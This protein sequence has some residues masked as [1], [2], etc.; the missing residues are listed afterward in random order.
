MAFQV[1][2]VV[3]TVDGSRTAPYGY[4][5]FANLQRYTIPHPFFSHRKD[6]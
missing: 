3:V 1:G 4:G 2:G 6:V 5:N